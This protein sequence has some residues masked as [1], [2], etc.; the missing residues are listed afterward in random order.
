[1]LAAIPIQANRRER[2]SLGWRAPAE[3]ISGGDTGRGLISFMKT[4]NQPQRE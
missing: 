4:V 3:D 2:R 1:M